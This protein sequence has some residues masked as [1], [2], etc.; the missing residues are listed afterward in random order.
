MNRW[1]VQDTMCYPSRWKVTTERP[2][3][4]GSSENA[5]SNYFEDRA[6]AYT[7]ADR[8]NKAEFNLEMER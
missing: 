5:T 4:E 3:G 2:R 1:I 6:A 8:R 7:E